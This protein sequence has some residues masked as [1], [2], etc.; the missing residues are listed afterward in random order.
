MD[1]NKKLYQELTP[2]Q[3]AIAAYAAVNRNDQT[4]IDRLMGAASRE[5]GLHKALRGVG[6]ALEAY[7]NL[8]SRAVIGFLQANGR[9]KAAVSF[10]IGWTSA[11]GAEDNEEYRKNCLIVEIFSEICDSW[12]GDI[13]EVQQVA[14]EWCEKNEIPVDFFSGPLCSYPL[15]DEMEEASDSE[16]LD[17]VRSVFDQITLG[18]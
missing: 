16:T 13:E 2:K 18:W 12:M 1:I 11:G 8:V 3:R 10:C 4:E 17:V 15:P 5:D 9:A 6:Q 7:N 14:W